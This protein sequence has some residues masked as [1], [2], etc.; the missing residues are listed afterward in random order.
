MPTILNITSVQMS[1]DV[2]TNLGPK[3]KSGKIL[4]YRTSFTICISG[5][6]ALYD[7]GQITENSSHTNALFFKKTIHFDNKQ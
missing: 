2:Q 3:T 1:E 5:S 7:H 6:V 4:K